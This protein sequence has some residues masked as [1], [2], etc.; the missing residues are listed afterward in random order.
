MSE[1]GR[2]IIKVITASV[3]AIGFFS[4]AFLVSTYLSMAVAMATGRSEA[5]A[6]PEGTVLAFDQSTKALEEISLI[7]L[8]TVR[9]V[10]DANITFD[11]GTQTVTFEAEG[12][13]V[14]MRVGSDVFTRNGEEMTLEVPPQVLGGRLLVPAHPLAE[15]LGAQAGWEQ[16]L[17][18]VAAASSGE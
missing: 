4:A 18:A 13:T 15:S 14:I 7:P 8:S 12:V 1:K 10:F 5:S 3:L 9:E 6:R 17:R 2:E 16:S 11:A